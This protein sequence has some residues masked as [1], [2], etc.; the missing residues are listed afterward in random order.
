MIMSNDDDGNYNG[1]DDNDIV[2]LGNYTS[3]LWRAKLILMGHLVTFACDESQTVVTS[4]ISFYRISMIC[5]RMISPA[6]RASTSIGKCRQRFR[7]F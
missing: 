4:L 3:V 2:S 5:G 1:L 6:V 7:K